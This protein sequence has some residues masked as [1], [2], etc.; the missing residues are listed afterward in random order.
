MQFSHYSRLQ[1]YHKLIGVYDLSDKYKFSDIKFNY[2]KNINI[3]YRL[4]KLS[5]DKLD[6]L[7]FQEIFFQRRFSIK[8]VLKSNTK[9]INLTLRKL[10]LFNCLELL[11][12]SYFL[13]NKQK[14]LLSSYNSYACISLDPM[15]N[16]EF[17]SYFNFK[18]RLSKFTI[19]LNFE[20]DKT[21]LN[22]ILSYYFIN[23]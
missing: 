11:L 15:Y 8:K 19:T 4:N 18:K 13:S 6:L 16:S 10:D 3:F 7:L 9:S 23:E 17:F 20:E 21:F 1:T 2:L 22:P 14:T 12:N 5:N